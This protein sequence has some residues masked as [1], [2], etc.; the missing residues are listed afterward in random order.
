MRGS[1][2]CDDDGVGEWWEGEEEKEEKEKKKRNKN[3]QLRFLLMTK[4]R[5]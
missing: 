4:I 3:V 5:Q 2:K 1:K